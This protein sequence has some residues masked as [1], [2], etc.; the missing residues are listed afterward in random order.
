MTTVIDVSTS[1]GQTIHRQKQR[2]L[3]QRS[4]TAA[5]LITAAPTTAPS[6]RGWLTLRNV[7]ARRALD[8]A[9]VL[10]QTSQLRP[11]GTDVNLVHPGQAVCIGLAAHCVHASGLSPEGDSHG[12]SLIDSMASV[13]RVEIEFNGH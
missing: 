9:A 2:Q 1:V 8:V 11:V 3:P 6:M 10:A 12:P 7:Q 4:T 13:N 5:T